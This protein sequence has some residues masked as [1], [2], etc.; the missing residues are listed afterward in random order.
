MI[1][2]LLQ[3]YGSALY[4]ADVQGFAQREVAEHLGLSVLGAKSGYS[5]HARSLVVLS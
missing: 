3:K 4:M 1:E 5:G 2:E